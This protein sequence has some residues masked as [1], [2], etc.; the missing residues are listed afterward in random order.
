MLY[1]SAGVL[2]ICEQACVFVDIQTAEPA[3]SGYAGHV[4]G[5]VKPAGCVY[6]RL[7]GYCHM[8][9]R[10]Q[11]VPVFSCCCFQWG[12]R[13][14][15]GSHWDFMGKCAPLSILAITMMIEK[16]FSFF[17]SIFYSFR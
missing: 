3:G 11:N 5:S 6:F 10:S 2:C 7:V 9:G 13:F 12:A 15:R 17:N 14:G 4:T 8:F 1:I 16:R